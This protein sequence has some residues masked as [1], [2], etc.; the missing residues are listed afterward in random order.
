MIVAA[1]IDDAKREGLAFRHPAFPLVQVINKYI[2]LPVHIE[3]K[4]D[5]VIRFLDVGKG[6]RPFSEVPLIGD[7]DEI[8]RVPVDLTGT[9]AEIENILSTAEKAAVLHFRRR[10]IGVG[11][12]IIRRRTGSGI[13]PGLI[14][15]I[16]AV[17]C[18]SIQITGHV[19]GIV[20]DF[21]YAR[22]MNVI[23][24]DRIRYQMSAIF[25]VV[26]RDGPGRQDVQDP[27]PIHGEIDDGLLV[28]DRCHIVSGTVEHQDYIPVQQEKPVHSHIQDHFP[29]LPDDHS[30]RTTKR[31]HRDLRVQFPGIGR[32][33]QCLV[34]IDLDLF[35]PPHAGNGKQDG[36]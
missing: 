15:Q 31:N 2:L 3:S 13:E 27:V 14:D 24:R 6:E 9:G 35:R 21:R 22:E 20:L 5:P 8:V 28:R 11:N 16:A 33:F 19:E 12:R 18:G 26:F 32:L 4:V 25:Y 1:V 10:D 29:S 34:D 23:V 7:A 17:I 36:D 30:L